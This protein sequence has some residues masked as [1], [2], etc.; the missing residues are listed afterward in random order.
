MLA[1]RLAECN[2]VKLTTPVPEYD[3]GIFINVEENLAELLD[4]AAHMIES[5]QGQR[6]QLA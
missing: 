4:H 3:K 2:Q 5:L 1:Q 6:E